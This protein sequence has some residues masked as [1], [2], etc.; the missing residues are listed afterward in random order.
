M[1]GR[2][3]ENYKSTRRE[4]GEGRIEKAGEDN[5]GEN[6]EGV[7]KTTG[8]RRF[9]TSALQPACMH[10]VP[11]KKENAAEVGREGGMEKKTSEAGGDGEKGANCFSPGGKKSFPGLRAI[12]LRLPASEK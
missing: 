3:K 11:Q 9:C 7:N 10:A 12:S 1:K 4:K 2:R 8:Y 5:K 6:V